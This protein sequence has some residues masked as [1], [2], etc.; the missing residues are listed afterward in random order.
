MSVT[1]KNWYLFIPH[2]ESAR[3]FKVSATSALAARAAVA[4]DTFTSE[5]IV[6]MSY[7]IVHFENVRTL[8]AKEAA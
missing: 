2:A 1:K 8:R 4:K 5:A 7:R 6:V 3:V